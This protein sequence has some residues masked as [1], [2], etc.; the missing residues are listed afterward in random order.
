M[1][2]LKS[3]I[4]EVLEESVKRPMIGININDEKQDFTGQILRG[5]KVIETRNRNAFRQIVG[6]RVG[7][8]RTGKGKGAT[9][10]GF[11]TIGQPIVYTNEEDFR[12][13]YE[14]HR[15]EPNSTYDIIKSPRGKKVGYPL[16][17]VKLVEPR[18]ITTVKMINNGG[19]GFSW[20]WFV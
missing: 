18:L 7:L 19:G 4:L 3:I 17:D 12:R 16:T 15:V 13:D 2:N 1:L 9:L 6:E 8:I 11:A 14:K 5:E 20:R 10:V